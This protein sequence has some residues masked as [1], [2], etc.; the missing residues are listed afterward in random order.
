[1]ASGVDESSA[2][3]EV[4]FVALLNGNIA[5]KKQNL[6]DQ[7][8]RLRKI[9]DEKENS[10]TNQIDKMHKEKQE[11]IGNLQEMR[12][13]SI[14]LK[15]I[16]SKKSNLLQ[17]GNVNIED[18]IAEIED[19]LSTLPTIE[20]KWD[21]DNVEN[22]LVNMNAQEVSG[23]VDTPGNASKMNVEF[24]IL[25]SIAKGSESSLGQLS[26]EL[27]GIVVDEDTGHVYIAD[28]GNSCIQVFGRDG[29]YL[30]TISH[31]LMVSPSS[32]SISGKHVYACN[33][34]CGEC[35][36]KSRKNKEQCLCRTDSLQCKFY[37]QYL[38]KFS[39]KDGQI[40]AFTNINSSLGLISADNR[41]LYLY[42][43]GYQTKFTFGIN[44]IT[45]S[46]STNVVESLVRYDEIF[47]TENTLSLSNQGFP[48]GSG[49]LNCAEKVTPVVAMQAFED[50]VHLLYRNTHIKSFNLKTGLQ[51]EIQL[52]NLTATIPRLI[53]DLCWNG[54]TNG[55]LLLT[56]SKNNLLIVISQLGRLYCELDVRNKNNDLVS[57]VAISRGAHS[58]SIIS[59]TGEE[60][61]M[62]H[63]LKL[64]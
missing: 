16:M 50:E 25:A 45:L 28:M 46:T 51:R 13:H 47:Q 4:D 58:Y 30:S 59:S 52:Q 27:G 34:K 41:S 21:L 26:K 39:K 31:E 33:R 7:F 40:I 19:Q 55:K 43:Y 48:S 3:T 12:S 56:D 42:S 8:V 32:I 1:M 53:S 36:I 15:R 38:L 22:S 60:C 44:E 37:N 20:N 64:A 6:S 35:N 14:A 57:P 5:N 61:W 63:G 9:L 2:G 29:V 62:L 11:E 54:K 49:C 23:S 17:L 18:S 24:E 10:I